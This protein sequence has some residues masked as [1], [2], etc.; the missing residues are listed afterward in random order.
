MRHG[1]GLFA[2]LDRHVS[3]DALQSRLRSFERE[4]ATLLD[5][6]SELAEQIS[7]LC[8][9][10]P[11]RGRELIQTLPRYRA[12]VQLRYRGLRDARAAV[13]DSDA[14]LRRK[15]HE[16]RRLRL[17]DAK[18]DDMRHT[19]RVWRPVLDCCSRALSG[20]RDP[21]YP[22]R[23]RF[24][25]FSNRVGAQD[26]IF[27]MLDRQLSG[28]Q[29]S[30]M[31]REHGCYADITLPMSQFLDHVLAARRVS[32]A[33][34]MTSP[35]RFLDVGCGGGVKVVTAR[36][37]FAET[38]GLEFDPGY[39]RVARRLIKR[40]RIGDVKIISGDA[41]EFQRF[42]EYDVIYFY[43]PMQDQ[44]KLLELER[45]IAG[46]APDGTILIAPYFEFLHRASELNCGR[47][48]GNIF[49]KGLSEAGARRARIRAERTGPALPDPRVDT[50]QVG[51]WREVVNALSTTGFLGNT[52]W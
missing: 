44:E 1:V 22:D 51:A 41:L 50:T 17:I 46:Q 5:A 43:K 10:R 19:F 11:A 23:P 2:C 38:D 9:G 42:A 40:E 21:L 48:D 52:I 8:N 32:V 12:R 6:I 45:R 24:H 16:R 30:D 3:T 33:L 29:Q 37:V 49:V 4:D 7:R 20:R 27:A 36:Q 31:G 13:D 39:A 35:T 28:T 18:L 26:R 34:G 47:I 25:P 14:A 15:P